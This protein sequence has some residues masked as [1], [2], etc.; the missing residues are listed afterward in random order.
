MYKEY[1]YNIDGNVIASDENGLHELKNHDLVK[2]QI[3]VENIIDLIQTNIKTREEDIEVLIPEEELVVETLLNAVIILL[4]EILLFIPGV[5]LCLF[6]FN[7]ALPFFPRLGLSQMI[8]I[9]NVL[10]FNCFFPILPKKLISTLKKY[11][12]HRHD[13]QQIA[14]KEEE[15]KLLNSLLNKKQADLAEILNQKTTNNLTTDNQIHSLEA[16]NIK[17]QTKLTNYLKKHQLLKLYKQYREKYASL[18]NSGLLN[19]TLEQ[20]QFS[21]E[22]IA[23]IN[24]LLTADATKRI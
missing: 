2:K 17:N 22:D 20:E 13:Q 1:T 21:P 6:G 19:S 9:I 24:Q 8:T 5:A 16:I 12:K 11:K 4:F 7:P 15:I 10:S 3:E 23:Y 14:Q 18:Y